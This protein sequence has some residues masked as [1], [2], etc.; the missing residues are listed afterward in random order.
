MKLLCIVTTFHEIA[1]KI[2]KMV[3][4]EQTHEFF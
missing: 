4:K 3:Q 1:L 2:L